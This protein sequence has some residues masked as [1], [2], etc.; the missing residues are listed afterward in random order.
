MTV[1]SRRAVLSATAGLFAAG[2]GCLDD[3][4]ADAPTGED[5]PDD[6]GTETETDA[7]LES[8]DTVS[9]RDS[10]APTDPD[11]TLLVDADATENWLAE[12]G[13][14]GERFDA[15]VDETAFE[16]SVVVALEADAPDLCH[17]MRIADV[18]VET[19]RDGEPELAV[20]AAVRDESDSDEV[21]AQQVTT[22]GRLVRATF[23]DE[24]PTRA[25]VTI[26]DRDREHEMAI[27]VDSAGESADDT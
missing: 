22:V 1:P 27:A 13:L 14:A 8:Y 26:A 10:S 24:P 23:A 11:A 9:F 12:R 7:T 19:D 5:D 3:A 4:E 15:F 25:T 20:E 18:A 17:G 2:A 6:S 16:D 21:C